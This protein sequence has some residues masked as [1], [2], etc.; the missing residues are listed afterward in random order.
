MNSR[1]NLVI[2]AAAS[3]VALLAGAAVAV[4]A[5]ATPPPADWLQWRGPMA[6]GEAAPDAKPPLTWSEDSHIRWKV[7]IPGCGR[8]TPIVWR[9]RIF[10]T[11][12]VK[13]ST[14]VDP[15][16]VKA[17]MADMPEFARKGAHVPEKV[18]QFVVMALKRSDGS[19]LWQK[20]VREQAPLAGTHADGSWASGSPVTDGEL[21]YVY[22]G[23]YGLYALTLD[24]ETKW[25]KDLGTF[26]TK[27][28]FGEGVSPVLCGDLLIVSQDFEGASFIVAFDRK[29]GDERWRVKRDEPT[30]WATPL[31]IEQGGKRRIVVSATNRIRCYD[32]DNGAVLWDVG[33]MTANVIPCPVTD[34]ERVFCMSGFRGSALLAIKLAVAAGDLTGKPEAIAWSAKENTPYVPSPVLSGG[35]L[36]YIKSND[37]FLSCVEA[38]TGKVQYANKLEGVPVVFASP[39]AAAGRLYVPGKNGMTLVVKLGPQFE[40]LATNKLNDGIIASPA[41]AGNSLLIRGDSRLYCIEGE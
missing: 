9:D 18:V 4:D 30:S 14:A 3:V 25:N 35:W 22:F 8:S 15:E 24:G 21:L 28:N 16:K 5:P 7:T 2:G 36:Y 11:T 33:G 37:G 12:A 29:S 26:K 23:S 19:V 27:A 39:V 32:A 1:S 13:T 41:V 38:A 6:T 20:T 40:V 17:V 31:V 34:G 10:L